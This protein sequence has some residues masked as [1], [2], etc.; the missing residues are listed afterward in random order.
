MKIS[1]A[2]FRSWL[3]VIDIGGPRSAD[4]VQTDHGDLILD[5]IFS[6][7]IYLKGFAFLVTARTGECTFFWI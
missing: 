1:E 4:L 2:D 7:R 5:K 3:D 6:G